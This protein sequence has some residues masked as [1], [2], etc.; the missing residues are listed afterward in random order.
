MKSSNMYILFE[1]SFPLHNKHSDAQLWRIDSS[2]KAF[3][4]WRPTDIWTS[5]L[6]EYNHS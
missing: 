3:T 1:R 2:T 4:D 5:F 6:C